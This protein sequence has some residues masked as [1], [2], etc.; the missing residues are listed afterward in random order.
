MRHCLGVSL[1]YVPHEKIQH[2]FIAFLLILAVFLCG[3]T[4][5]NPLPRAEQGFLDLTQWSLETN[6]IVHLDGEWE[7]Y[8]NRLLFPDDFK[9][10]VRPEKTGFF[11]I[12]GFWNGDEADGEILKGEGY[13]T[14]RLK[15]M[16]KPDQGTLAVRLENQATSYRLWVN[17]ELILWNGVVGT[18]RDAAKPQYLVR[19]SDIDQERHDLEF[20]L[21]VSNFSL[22]PSP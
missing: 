15:V 16:L 11:A 2:F 18:D 4:R 17:N 21:Q 12:P 14:F 20:I 13:A 19:I 9:T 5:E 1:F 8:W 10:P 7:F 3:C 6:G 22:S